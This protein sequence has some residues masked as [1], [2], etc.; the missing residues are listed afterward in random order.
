MVKKKL[1]SEIN[2]IKKTIKE[3]EDEFKYKL[4][5]N[6]KMASKIN[7]QF[8]EI[9]RLV[10][11]LKFKNKVHTFKFLYLCDYFF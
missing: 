4:Y 8:E 2:N 11:K 9:Q 1:L 10:G 7:I 5:C 6:R 3:Y